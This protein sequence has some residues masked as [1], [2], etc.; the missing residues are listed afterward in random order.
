MFV[1]LEN[2][3]ETQNRTGVEFLRSRGKLGQRSDAYKHDACDVV[4]VGGK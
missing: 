1:G 2:L 3:G 4:L